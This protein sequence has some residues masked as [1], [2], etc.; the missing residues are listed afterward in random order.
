M[1]AYC[2]AISALNT[3][4]ITYELKHNSVSHLIHQILSLL[5]NEIHYMNDNTAT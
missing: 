2:V 5:K 4:R 3:P 1:G